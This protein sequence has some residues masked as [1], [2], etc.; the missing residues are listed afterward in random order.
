FQ[1]LR[2]LS[3]IAST[4]GVGA[5]GAEFPVSGLNSLATTTLVFDPQ[6]GQDNPNGCPSTIGYRKA[7]SARSH[8][9]M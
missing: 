8:C 1:A 7:H 6:R 3:S 2:T 9:R 5:E 4:T